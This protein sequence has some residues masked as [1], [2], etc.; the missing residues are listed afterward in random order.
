MFSKL[1]QLDAII[2]SKCVKKAFGDR[3]WPATQPEL[4]ALP[5]TPQLDLRGCIAAQKDR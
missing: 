4:T 2:D 3:Y 1:L 5:Q